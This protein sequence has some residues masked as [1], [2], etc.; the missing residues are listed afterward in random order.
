MGGCSFEQI[1]WHQQLGGEIDQKAETLFSEGQTDGE[2][3]HQ[4]VILA[5][6]RFAQHL[7]LVQLVPAAASDQNFREGRD[8]IV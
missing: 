2:Q 8:Y 6:F 1:V 5:L 4:L 3:K 7:D